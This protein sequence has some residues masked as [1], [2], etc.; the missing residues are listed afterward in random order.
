[1][2]EPE[3]KK[4][5]KDRLPPSLKKYRYCAV[6]NHY[7]PYTVCPNHNVHTSDTQFYESPI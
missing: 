2:S 7:T 1:M 3:I 4:I 5:D 6:G